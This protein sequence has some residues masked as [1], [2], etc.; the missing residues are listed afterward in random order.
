MAKRILIVDDSFF[1]RMMIKKILTVNEYEVVGEAKNGFEAV[2]MYRQ[3]KPDLVTMDITM[4]DMSGIESL[5]AI[6]LIDPCAKV[7]MLSAMSQE[8][9]LIEA[10]ELGAVG[11]VIKPFSKDHLLQAVKKALSKIYLP[12]YSP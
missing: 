3:L 4:P 9:F 2:M 6:R 8:N 11:Y 7:I 1:M 12:K 10:F 5:K